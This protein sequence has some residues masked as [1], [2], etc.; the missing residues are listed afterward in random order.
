MVQQQENPQGA[1]EPVRQADSLANTQVEEAR[2]EA[3]VAA[4]V[5][6]NN[7]NQEAG[8]QPVVNPNELAAQEDPNQRQEDQNQR[9][10]DPIIEPPIVV[11]ADPVANAPVAEVANNG[12]HGGENPDEAALDDEEPPTVVEKLE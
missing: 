7:P 8:V 9:Q 3:N 5:A 6:E 2:S 1:T 12:L 10:E 4:P 11:V